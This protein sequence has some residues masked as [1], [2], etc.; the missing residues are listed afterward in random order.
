[1]FA[2]KNV[3]DNNH[4][5]TCQERHSKRKY[6]FFVGLMREMVGADT[7]YPS[8]NP[9][10]DPQPDPVSVTGCLCPVPVAGCLCPVPVTG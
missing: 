7:V 9:G 1:M 8:P 6:M 5:I 4:A 10:P 3:D 2:C